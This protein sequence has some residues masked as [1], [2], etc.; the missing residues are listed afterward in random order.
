MLYKSHDDDA[1]PGHRLI[2]RLMMLSLSTHARLFGD[3]VSAEAA[4]ENED[5]NAAT[6]D[7][8][9]DKGAVTVSAVAKPLLVQSQ[10]KEWLLATLGTK[11][12]V[13]SAWPETKGSGLAAQASSRILALDAKAVS[14]HANWWLWNL[15]R[16]AFSRR[17]SI[18]P[19]CSRGVSVHCV[20]GGPERSFDWFPA[21]GIYGMNPGIIDLF[22]H[23]GISVSIREFETSSIEPRLEIQ[24]QHASILIYNQLE[25]AAHGVAPAV[26]AAFLVHEGDDY[27][28]LDA[29]LR[30]PPTAAALPPDQ[31]AEVAV[32]TRVAAAVVLGQVHSFR[33]TDMLTA[34]AHNRVSKDVVMNAMVAVSSK[35]K[36]LANLKMLKL[37]MVA[38]NVVFCPQ[39]IEAEDDQLELRGF[40]YE[41]AGGTEALKG[42]PFL[43][44]FDTRLSKRMTMQDGYNAVAAYVTMMLV[45]LA[46]IRH[47]FGRRVADDMMTTLKTA[48]FQA[49]VDAAKPMIDTFADV[50]RRS[51]QTGR[52]ERDALPS[53]LVLEIAADLPR[54]VRDEETGGP[55][56][57]CGGPG[58]RQLLKKLL[59]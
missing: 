56:C 5:G 41:Q 58:F 43:C 51:F 52:M 24:V 49:D 40:T 10:L 1:E 35:V 33:M 4:D 8:P 47:Q 17:D 13:L 28:G 6:L 34:Y 48:G 20:G 19:R 22:I 7:P 3:D 32:G 21:G 18:T 39:L 46:A 54:R 55:G 45:L 25:A 15:R 12:G 14:G 9:I 42:K 50:I 53:A 26:F 30:S 23:Y 16:T 11:R 44:D 29:M 36:Q 57:G 2:S 59:S 27:K 31:L 37:N 38:D